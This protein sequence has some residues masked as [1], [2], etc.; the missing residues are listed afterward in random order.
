MKSVVLIRIAIIL[1]FVHCICDTR[2]QSISGVINSYYKVTSINSSTNSL[3][4]TNAAGLVPSTKVMLMQMK[5]AVINNTNTASFGD[6][7]SIGE[8]GQYEFNMVCGVAGNEVLLKY[9][10]T[11]SYNSLESLQLITVPQYNIVTVAGTV[12]ASP[13]DAASGTG[14]IVVLEADTLYLNSGIN[15]TGQG[16]AGGRFVNFPSPAY[17][18]SWSVNVTNYFMQMTMADINYS[19][20]PKGE[21][22]AQYITNAEYGRGKQANGGG[23]GNNHN[24]G[25]AGGGNYGLGGN[26]GQRSNETFFLC[27]GTNPGIGGLA[28]ASFGYTVSNNRIF[29]GGGGGSGHQN[30]SVG[31]RGGT[32]GGIVLIS[33]NV[34]VATGT[35]I[36]ANGLTPVNPSNAD[37]YSADGD[38]G[39]GGGAGGTIIL[40]INELIGNISTSVTGGRG[41]DAGRGIGDCTGPGGGGGGGLVWMKGAAL[42]PGVSAVTNG[43]VNGVVSP[44]SST[45]V[46]RGLANGATSGGAGSTLSGYVAPAMGN[47]LCV[48]LPVPELIFFKGRAEQGNIQ[49]WWSMAT[50]DNIKNYVVERSI[51]QV[52]YKTISRANNNGEYA[53]SMN[54]KDDFRGTGFYR[55]KLIRSNGTIGYSAVLA[56]TNLRNTELNQLQLFPNPAVDELRVSVFAKKNILSQVVIFNSSGQRVHQQQVKIAVGLN[57]ILLSIQK[58][59]SGPYWLMFDV[60]GV[61]E[62]K[63]FIKLK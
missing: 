10:L 25:G 39:G 3:T 14:G 27:H 57:T 7:T 37:P 31:I 19:G 59:Q 56:I 9:E 32:G 28:V 34:L 40:N 63:K 11:H 15:V 13:W 16:F 4:V 42:L 36:E 8:A 24:T 43:G 49:L 23:G 46:C 2:A 60:N 12:T 62:R 58:L 1:L 5:G 44:L 18:C 20:A 22:I 53:L 61:Q 35:S 48:P 50:I 33:A 47:F 52:N 38:G 51:D 54:I 17:S 6:V 45:A 21:G 26:G 29:M 41:T 30:N 55:L